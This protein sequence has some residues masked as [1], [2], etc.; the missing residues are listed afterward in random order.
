MAWPPV[1]PPATR[2]DSTT[3]QSNHPDDHNKI[4]EA[5]G[6]LRD[7]IDEGYTFSA[8][9][10]AFGQPPAGPTN[11]PVNWSISQHSSGVAWLDPANSETIIFPVAGTY[12][13]SATITYQNVGTATRIRNNINIGSFG[14]AADGVTADS[15]IGTLT[16]QAIRTVAAGDT[17]TVVAW[18][19]AQGSLIADST[20]LFILRL[21]D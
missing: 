10:T 14:A 1:I 9:F 6:D 2:S 21:G 17:L 3:Q 16:N 8:G 13:V 20:S 15:G 7:R 5:L 18:A 11:N 19:G 12:Y 4:S